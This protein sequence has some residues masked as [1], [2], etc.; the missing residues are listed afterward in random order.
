[1]DADGF[2]NNS[3]EYFDHS[4]HPHHNSHHQHQQPH[5][6]HFINDLLAMTTTAS[7]QQTSNGSPMHLLNG[8]L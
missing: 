1:M 2:S 3:L 4:H 5:G 8:K 7:T 6:N